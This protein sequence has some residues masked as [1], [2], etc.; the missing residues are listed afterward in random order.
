MGFL[1]QVGIEAR[2]RA[3][4]Y[5]KRLIWILKLPPLPR[6]EHPDFL[7]SFLGCR[8]EEKEGEMRF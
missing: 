3:L 7:I 6:R 8:A 4:T 5:R 2:V 1:L